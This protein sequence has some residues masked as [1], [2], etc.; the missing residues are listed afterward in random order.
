MMFSANRCVIALAALAVPAA[1]ALATD[2]KIDADTCTQLRLEQIKFRQTGIVDDIQKGPEWAKA[3]LTPDRLREVE[4]YMALDEQVKFGCRDAK[5]SPEAEKASEA[6]SRI[7]INSDADPTAPEGAGEASSSKAS[8]PAAAK[9]PVHKR[10]THKKPKSAAPEARSI[11]K[12]SQPAKPQVTHSAM[13]PTSAAPPEVAA[14]PAPAT[15]QVAPEAPALGF[16]ETLV[17]PHLSP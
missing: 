8:N 9:P 17:Q 12:A 15:P 1:T 14:G 2:P 3:N 10:T 13:S 16:G 5:L 11:D 4:H 6:A 7:E